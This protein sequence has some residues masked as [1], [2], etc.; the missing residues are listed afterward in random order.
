MVVQ[1]H[2]DA[3]RLSEDTCGKRR[4]FYSTPNVRTGALG[5]GLLSGGYN[6]DEFRR[7]GGYRVYQ[8]LLD[9]LQHLDEV[10]IRLAS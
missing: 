3:A 5:I 10:G 1:P 9:L 8:D 2:P 7:A 4:I 6:Q